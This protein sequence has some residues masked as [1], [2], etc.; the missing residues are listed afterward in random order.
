MTTSSQAHEQDESE[1]GERVQ[2]VKEASRLLQHR[3]GPLRCARGSHGQAGTPKWTGV[4]GLP[5]LMQHAAAGG[6]PTDHTPVSK[7]TIAPML[8]KAQFHK[9]CAQNTYTTIHTH[10]RGKN[11]RKS[12]SWNNNSA[13]AQTRQHGARAWNCELCECVC[14]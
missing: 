13:Q 9:T 1:R 14:V 4:W 10:V 7:N 6:T 11:S 2:G 12:R 5:R 3:P 8:H